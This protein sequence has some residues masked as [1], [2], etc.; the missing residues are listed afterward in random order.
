MFFVSN[1]QAMAVD[2]N[3]PQEGVLAAGV[4]RRLFPA[5]LVSVAAERNAWDVT[6]DGQR[7]L[8]NSSTSQAAQVAGQVTP[9]TVVVN[10][11]ASQGRQAE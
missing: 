8:V 1:G 2:V 6:L 5:S 4:P 7:F 10:W 11:L 9:I 3:V